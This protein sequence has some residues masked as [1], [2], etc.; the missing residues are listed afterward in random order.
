MNNITICLSL[1]Y[2]DHIPIYTTAPIVTQD[3]KIHALFKKGKRAD[4]E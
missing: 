1:L 4:K 3:R 2:D